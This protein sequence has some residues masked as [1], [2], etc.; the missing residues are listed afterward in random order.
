[1]RAYTA[2]NNALR[3]KSGLGYDLFDTPDKVINESTIRSWSQ[4]KIE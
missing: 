1:V 3:L 2:N 4:Q